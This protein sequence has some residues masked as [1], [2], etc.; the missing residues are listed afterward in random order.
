MITLAG[1]C[2]HST[3]V[4]AIVP[5]FCLRQ[6]SKSRRREKFLPMVGGAL[7]RGGKEGHDRRKVLIQST[8]FPGPI[9]LW[10]IFLSSVWVEVFLG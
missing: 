1:Y 6:L 9:S 8:E 7:E 4:P 2:V 5:N 3:L 10:S